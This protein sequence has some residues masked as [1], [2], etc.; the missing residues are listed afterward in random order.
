MKTGDSS[1]TKAFPTTSRIE[2]GA[3]IG[4]ALGKVDLK[5]A[6]SAEGQ[7]YQLAQSKLTSLLCQHYHMEALLYGVS[8]AGSSF[9]IHARRRACVSRF[10]LRIDA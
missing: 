9:I 4:K 5:D 1:R 6:S 3:N 7:C 2:K 8:M 10:L